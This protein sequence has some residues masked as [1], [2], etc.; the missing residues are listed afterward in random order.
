[1]WMLFARAASPD[2]AYWPGR[3]CLAAVDAVTWPALTC[4]ALLQ[5]LASGGIVAALAVALS[6]LSALQ[7][8]RTALMAN[9]RYH[10][11]TWRWGRLAA[12]LL[13]FGALL[14]VALPP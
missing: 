7:R 13:A 6:A 5:M 3:R 8:L 1:M 12:W 2:V 4:F 14:K 10:F 9:H 11:T